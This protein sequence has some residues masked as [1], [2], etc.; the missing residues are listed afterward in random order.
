MIILIN[1][2][3]KT[4]KYEITVY[5]YICKHF[6]ISENIFYKYI[7]QLACKDEYSNILIFKNMLGLEKKRKFSNRF[8][9]TLESTKN[10]ILINFLFRYCYINADIL[11]IF[12][13]YGRNKIFIESERYMHEI[14]QISKNNN[15]DI[16]VIEQYQNKGILNWKELT[17]HKQMT[18]RELYKYEQNIF[19]KY[20]HH[21]KNINADLAVA[22]IN[23]INR[24]ELYVA[25]PEIFLN[26]TLSFIDY[27][28]S[29][30]DYLNYNGEFDFHIVRYIYKMLSKF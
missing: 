8:Y 2:Y 30:Y 16:D 18:L 6:T 28:I 10:K 5:E 4:Y 23:S 12:L 7:A 14:E 19:W 3:S 9:Y 27:K 21:Q 11:E 22:H 25:K 1:L 13:R 17:Q 26:T 15:I 24:I 29:L 20:V